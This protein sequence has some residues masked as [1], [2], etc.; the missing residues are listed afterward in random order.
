MATYIR[1][2]S[3][4]LKINKREISQKDDKKWKSGMVSG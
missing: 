2:Y 1:G 3:Q 4:R